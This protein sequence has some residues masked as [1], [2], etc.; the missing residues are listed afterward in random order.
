MGYDTSPCPTESGRYIVPVMLG[1]H[2]MITNVLLLNLLIARFGYQ[3][4]F[5][6]FFS[7]FFWS[8]HLCVLRGVR[9]C[10]CMCLCR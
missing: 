6:L 3:A 10:V 4:C 7:F 5:L 2:V 9:V 8:M 1:I